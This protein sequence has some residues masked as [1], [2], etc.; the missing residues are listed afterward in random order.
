MAEREAASSAACSK[1]RLI[2]K[3][4][5]RTESKLLRK[6]HKRLLFP[7]PGDKILWYKILQFGVEY[8]DDNRTEY[9]VVRA[10]YKVGMTAA[11]LC[12][13]IWGVLPLYWQALR[14][15]E[16]SVIIFYRIV[17]VGAVS[18]VGALKFYGW[19]KIWQPLRAKG[20]KLRF[21]LAG[22]LITANWSIYIWAVNA[23]H[24]IQTCIGYYIEP[25]MVCIFGVILF[26]EKLSK[27]KV[28][29]LAMACVGVVIILVH[30]REVPVIALSL[31]ASFATYAALKKSF[32]I[33]AV[34]SL[35]YET[36]FLVPPAL[37]VII[38]MEVTGNGALGVGEPYQFGLLLLCGILTAIPLGLFAVA[39]NKITLVTLGIT[40]YLS[41]SIALVI[42]IYVLGEAFD[43]IQ[44]LA[45]AVIWVGLIIFT[46]GEMRA[47]RLE[48]IS[49]SEGEEEQ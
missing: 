32:K 39:A 9:A 46:A 38:W 29:A 22:V 31:A 7:V 24:V 37:A 28:I 12:A 30:F 34:L 3:I 18:F 44:F 36:M 45:F 11:I 14:P 23:E 21:F 42:G 15:I 13:V 41:P 27:H 19:K 4:N 16:S 5:D 26:K 20:V 10:D 33:Q 2:K 40:E 35:L 43:S 48:K 17:L 25:L 47:S 6:A 8:M 49:E 1:I